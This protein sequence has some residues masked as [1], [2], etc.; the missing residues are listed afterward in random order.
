MGKWE[1]KRL[2]EIASKVTDGSHN[3]PKKVEVGYPMYS[4]RNLINGKL[5]FS[6]PSR[7]VDEEGFEKENKRTNIQAGD[8]FLSIVGSIGLTAV[9]PEKFEPFVIQRSIALIRTKENSEF[10]RYYFESPTFQNYLESNSKGAAQKGIYLTAL[11]ATKIPLPPLPEQQRIVA[12]LDDL[13]A[14]IDQAIG[15]LEENITHTQALMGSV[16]DEE[17]GRLA[18]KYKTKTLPDVIKKDRHSIKRGPFGSALKKAFFVE[19]GYKVYEQKNAIKNDFSL[20]HYYINDEKFEELKGFQVVP[21]DIIISCS[22]TIGKIAIA[23]K[24]IKKGIINQALLK[25][26]LDN[27]VISNDYFTYF[28][29][30]F[31]N[32]GELKTKGAAIKNIVSVKELKKIPFALPTLTEQNEIVKSIKQQEILFES[33]LKT[34]NQK[35]NHLKA[36]KSSL[37]DQAFKGEL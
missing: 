13:F 33:V 1:E 24:N 28:F 16:L 3:P 21:G 7:Y 25:I 22:G 12:K 18:K 36:L 6:N 4:G 20:G 11:R 29:K 27:S 10:L 37:L 8:I 14:K 2:D 17:F 5:D 34:Q 26:S 23:P 31:V 15:L 32:Q 35:L 19:K 30:N 9:V